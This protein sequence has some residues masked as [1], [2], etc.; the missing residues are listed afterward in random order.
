MN[1]Q[2]QAAKATIDSYVVFAG[3]AAF[4]SDIMPTVAL[5]MAAVLSLIRIIN[6]WPQLT[7]TVKGWFGK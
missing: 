2:D 3:V 6:E 5:L 4:V 7:K 1:I